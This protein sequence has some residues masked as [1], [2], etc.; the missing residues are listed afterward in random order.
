M[1]ISADE[2]SV[3]RFGMACME[4]VAVSAEKVTVHRVER[5]FLNEF[6]AE[7][8]APVEEGLQVQQSTTNKV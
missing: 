3:Y 1:G 6:C 4:R 5:C 7:I 2:F 8:K